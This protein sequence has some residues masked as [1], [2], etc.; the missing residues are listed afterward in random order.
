MIETIDRIQGM[1]CDISIIVLESSVG[2]ALQKNRFNVAT[3]RAKRGTIIIARKDFTLRQSMDA[4][5]KSFIHRAK[6]HDVAP[7]IN[8]L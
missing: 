3:S 4:K 2:F 6:K 8:P 7:E 1:T 5:V